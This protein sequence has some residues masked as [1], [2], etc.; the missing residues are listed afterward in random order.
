MAGREAECCQLHM[1]LWGANS[2]AEGCAIDQSDCSGESRWSADH[3]RG[4]EEASNA[5]RVRFSHRLI[6]V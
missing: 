6:S 2:A 4:D 1:A 3:E 5:T